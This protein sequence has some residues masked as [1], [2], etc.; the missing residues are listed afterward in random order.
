[1]P[2]SGYPF[3][4]V[5][6]RMQAQQGRYTG[7]FH[8]FTQI[9]RKEGARAL[10][11]GMTSPVLGGAVETGVNYMVYSSTLRWLQGSAETAS[12]THVGIAAATGGMALSVVVSPVELVKCRL[13]LGA[14]DRYHTYSGPLDCLR[15]TVQ[16]EGA[17]GLTR[18][19]TGTL[20]REV[21][22][23]ALYFVT[24]QALRRQTDELFDRDALRGPIRALYEAVSAV[25]CGGWA[26]VAMWA[27]VFPVDAAKTQVQTSYPGS[28]RGNAGLATTLRCMWH[29][30]GVAA[31]YSGLSPTLIRAFPAN[32]CQWLAWE[33]SM[34]MYDH[35]KQR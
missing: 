3:D 25:V 7:P 23:N 21:P 16:Q 34:Q 27:V 31:V 11:R 29:K 28:A 22:G 4:T 18:G 24:Y 15:K 1:M 33:A 8:C 17:W 12:L 20:A 35:L 14:Y 19:F 13:Q 2:V 32:A 26:G 5:K 6:V 9:V 30:G 10:F